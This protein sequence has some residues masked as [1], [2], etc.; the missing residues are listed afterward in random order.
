MS[1]KLGYSAIR[2][3]MMR[4]SVLGLGHMGKAVGLRLRDQGYEVTVWNRTPG[5]AEVL[6]Q[7]GAR[8]AASIAHALAGAD[9]VITLLT[10]D[11]AVEQVALGADGAIRHLPAEAVLVDMSTVYPD[12]SRTLAARTPGG[13]FIDA[14]ILGGPEALLNG[15]AKL[16]I[17]GHEDLV[18]GLD[19]L[20]TDL[21]ASYIYTGANGTAT[22]LKLLSNLSLVGGTALLAEAVATAQASGIHNEVLRQVFGQSPAVAPGVHLRMEDILQGDHHG[23]WSLELAD[24]DM[25]LILKLGAAAGTRLPIA[26]ATEALIRKAIGA[27][28]GELDLGAMVEAIRKSPELS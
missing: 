3:S 24:K 15:K 20:W 19:P 13:R 4:V 5:R 8:E 26:E 17:S 23:W 21:S 25:T 14:P 11:T 22:T 12:T 9:V 28:Y 2:R 16:L 27:G 7:R 1:I 18:K 6:V 10:N